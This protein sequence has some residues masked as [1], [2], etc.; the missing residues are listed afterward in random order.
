MY[1]IASVS[2][3]PVRI[4]ITSSTGKI[5]IFPFTKIGKWWK[6]DKEIDL[7]ALNE[8]TKE[9]L[10]CECKWKDKV[11]AEKVVKELV[12]EKIPYV[13]WNNNDRKESIAVFAKSF[14]KRIEEFD[15]RKVY[16]FDLRDLEKLLFRK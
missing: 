9:I 10:F 12:E 6:K 1:Y 13:D 8:Q 2:S 7:I 16:C 5:K 11:N 3:S 4:R 14:S 15:G